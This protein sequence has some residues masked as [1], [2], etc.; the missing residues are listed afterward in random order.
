MHSE[1]KK[2]VSK[3]DNSSPL[4]IQLANNLKQIILEG[5]MASGDSLPSER[6]LTEITGA[7]RVTVR[8]AI[9]RLIEEGLLLSRQGAGTFVAP[10][11]EQSGEELTSFTDDAQD[12]GEE[13]A[14]I[15]L[16]RSIAS[17]TEEEARH[18]KISLNDPV[19]RL[20]RVRLSD[21]EPLAIEHAVIPAALLP[22]HENV[23][24]SLY[25]ALEKIGVYPVKGTQKIR[26]SLATPTEAALL[27]IHEESEILR[28]ERH[29]FTKDGTP[30]E[31]TRSAYRGDKYVFVSYLHECID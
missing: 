8:K 23:G 4:Y 10:A 11:I 15:W 9:R 19:V 22:S 3:W 17:P 5:K 28:I 21:G 1:L 2:I 16:V 30:V 14:S 6:M 7:S 31:Y 29:T 25:Q 26:A 13:P 27:S 18:L 12:R 24:L 20:G